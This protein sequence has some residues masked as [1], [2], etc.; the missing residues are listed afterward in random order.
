MGGFK[1]YDSFIQSYISATCPTHFLE[2]AIPSAPLSFLKV[3][4]N[5]RILG[6]KLSRPHL[7]AD[8]RPQAFIT[9]LSACRGGG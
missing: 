4:F 6:K 2:T 7:K 5:G 8:L 9:D 3:T 1:Q